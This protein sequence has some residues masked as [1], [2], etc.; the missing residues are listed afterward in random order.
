MFL[1]AFG[2]LHGSHEWLEIIL[3]QGTWFNV[4]FPEFI[5]WVRVGFLAISFA[6]LFTYGVMVL[7]PQTSSYAGYFITPGLLFGYVVLVVSLIG[8]PSGVLED[9]IGKADALARYSLAVPGAICAAS[10]LSRQSYHVINQK[11][12]GLPSS[13]RFAAF[14]FFIYGLTQTIGPPVAIWPAESINTET[15]RAFTGF[16]VQLLRA[17]MAFLVMIGLIRAT[18]LVN[19]ERQHQLLHA[20]QTRLEALER[21]QKELIK[22]EDLRR[23]LL[24]RTVIA[25]EEERARIARELHDETAQTLTAFSINVAA[26]KNRSSGD[27]VYEKMISSLLS[28]SDKMTS[29]INR[30]IHD[31]HPTQLDDLGLAHALQDLTENSA[32]NLGLAVRLKIFGDIQRV[33]SLIETVLYRVAQE[34]ITNVVRHAQTSNAEMHLTFESEKIKLTIRDEGVG[35]VVIDPPSPTRGF[36][37]AFMRERVDSTGGNLSIRSS[38]GKGTII[39][40]EIPITNSQIPSSTRETYE[41]NIDNVN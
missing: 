23:E 4:Q 37:L 19:K 1:A 17:I 38:P 22:Q 36:G 14:G 24:K 7:R 11:Q 15:F 35:F 10:A 29:D 13:L 6:M 5:S 18:Q 2:F 32:K 9:W 16:P 26:L 41:K 21:V 28:L 30:I 3:M 8:I 12:P 39:E 31:L 33:D 40:V 20:Q 25:Q 34:T 27:K